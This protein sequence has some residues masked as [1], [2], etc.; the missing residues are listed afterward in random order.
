MSVK[1]KRNPSK[2]DPDAFQGVRST[3]RRIG[4]GYMNM[5]KAQLKRVFLQKVVGTHKNEK[6]Q[7]SAINYLVLAL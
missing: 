4:A 1:E 6:V 7:F 3:G 2:Y 5:G